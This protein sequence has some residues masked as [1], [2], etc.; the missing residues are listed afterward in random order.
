MQNNKELENQPVSLYQ[1][2]NLSR[3]PLLDEKNSIQSS[4][5]GHISVTWQN[6][7]LLQG[8]KSM[9]FSFLG[10]VDRRILR[11][12]KLWNVWLGSFY[13]RFSFQNG[14]F[15]IKIPFKGRKVARHF[16]RIPKEFRW[17]IF[18][19][20]FHPVTPSWEFRIQYAS[21]LSLLRK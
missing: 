3:F 21:Q 15:N 13:F 2:K 10:N 9:L 19:F 20:P 18:K 6:V 12:K 5:Y 7:L 14:Y 17:Y 11:A 16:N 4:R 1:K 8:A